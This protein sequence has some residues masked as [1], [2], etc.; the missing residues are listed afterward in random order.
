MGEEPAR[1]VLA[2]PL[3]SKTGARS[4]RVPGVDTVTPLDAALK[5]ITLEMEALRHRIGNGRMPSSLTVH[6]EFDK[7]TGQL[8]AVDVEEHRRR[9]VNVAAVGRRRAS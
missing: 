8:R 4:R 9:H 2:L 3:L 1:A 7:D 5:E 6:V